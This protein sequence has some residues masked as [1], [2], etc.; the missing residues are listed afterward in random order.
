[1]NLAMP[2]HFPQKSFDLKVGGMTCASCVTRVEK[3]LRNVPGVTAATVNLA[4]E[5]ASVQGETAVTAGVLAAAV[6]QAGYEARRR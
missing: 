3:A 4:T 5:R 1:M 2:G 6:H